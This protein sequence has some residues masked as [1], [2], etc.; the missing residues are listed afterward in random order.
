MTESFP[1]TSS[2]VV[3]EAV[4]VRGNKA[5]PV[6][7]TMQYTRPLN[8][9]S[10]V[11]PDSGAARVS[12]ANPETFVNVDPSAGDS[13]Q[14]VDTAQSSVMEEAVS[15]SVGMETPPSVNNGANTLGRAVQEAEVAEGLGTVVVE[16]VEEEGG[17]RNNAAAKDDNSE[18]LESYEEVQLQ[19]RNA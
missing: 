18:H 12:V 4:I 7:S 13:T 5:V 14:A 10:A 11:L 3:A 17:A 16:V 19:V 15:A 1:V 9:D 6:S 8:G 2:S